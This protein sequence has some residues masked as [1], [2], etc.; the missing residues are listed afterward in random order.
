MIVSF[1]A[2]NFM[3]LMI[4]LA[5]ATMMYV[6]RDVKI[7]ATKLFVVSIFVMLAVAVAGTFD[8]YTD[9][10][11]MAAE[12]AARIVRSRLWASTIGYILRPLV[13]L[14]EVELLLRNKVFRILW[15][16]PAGVNALIYITALFGNRYVFTISSDNHWRGGPLHFAVYVTLLLYLLVLLYCSIQSF[17]TGDK[18]KS[19]MLFLIFLQALL[20][21]LHEYGNN[22]YAS[23]TNEVMALCILE[24]YM[25]LTN[26]YRQELNERLDAYVDK[27]EETG[28]KLKTLTQEVIESLASAIDAKD[29]Y[30]H[31][32]SSR[33]AEY[34]RKIAKKYGKSEQECDEIY[35]A[36]LLHDVGK[37]GIADSI[38]TKAGKLTQEE[39]EE[40]KKHPTL[41]TQILQRISAFPFLSLGASGHHERYDGKGYPN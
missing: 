36:A 7:P 9:V 32:H 29:E 40:I 17:R 41:G 3:T 34:S 39:Y 13:I 8:V 16:I 28:I 30:T 1:F 35:Y 37:I 14:A 21:A 24:Y 12:E 26:V 6:N 31:G 38:I 19:M 20:V 22:L 4:L 23:Y 25:Y 15:M 5:T 2:I 33:V 27:I 11:G 10:S 18:R